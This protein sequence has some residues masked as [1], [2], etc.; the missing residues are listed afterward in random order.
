MGTQEWQEWDERFKQDV[1]LY[2]DEYNRL[3]KALIK[4]VKGEMKKVRYDYLLNWIGPY[5]SWIDSEYSWI[6]IVGDDDQIKRDVDERVIYIV[7]NEYPH[8]VQV[9]KENNYSTLHPRQLIDLLMYFNKMLK[10][11]D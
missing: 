10:R 6:E 2:P 1:G 3:I 9:I 8:A 7:D 5:N 4:N 11:N